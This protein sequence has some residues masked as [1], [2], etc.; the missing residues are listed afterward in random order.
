MSR[1]TDVAWCAGFFDGEGHVGYHRSRP[2]TKSGIVSPMLSATIPQNT[3]NIETLEFFQSTIGFGKLY[4]PYDTAKGKTR[5][6]L[7][8]RT[9]EIE[10]LFF[11][12]KPYLRKEKSED[13]IRALYQ[14]NTHNPNVTPD[15][16]AR[17]ARLGCP[18][19]K[20][21]EKWNG[22]MCIKCGHGIELVTSFNM[23]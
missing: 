23:R 6:D 18:K 21:K 15:D 4:G 13:F 20:D 8:Y 22:M 5:H 10:L 14:F 9:G 12:L 1:E 19:C 16:I 7:K 3:E 2:S 17:L 11:T